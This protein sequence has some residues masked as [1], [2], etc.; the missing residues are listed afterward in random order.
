VTRFATW[1]ARF[2]EFV[3]LLSSR[4]LFFASLDKVQFHR[5]KF[6]IV[7]VIILLIRTRFFLL[8][9]GRW[10]KEDFCSFIRLIV[11]FFHSFFIQFVVEIDDYF[12]EI[13]H[14]AN[15]FAI[16]HNFVLKI[17]LKIL[18]KHCHKC[19]IVSLNKIGIFLKSC[20]VLCYKDSLS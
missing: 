2:L 5:C 13:K 20:Y 14:I 6:T 10:F 11:S 8:I 1:I 18:S 7:W 3:I 16:A 4:V 17:V 12:D 19:D 15:E 9:F